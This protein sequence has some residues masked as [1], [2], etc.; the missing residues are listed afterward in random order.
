MKVKVE[1]LSRDSWVISPDKELL[2]VIG[3][4][5]GRG[6]ITMKHILRMEE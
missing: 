4:I 2:Y 5:F 6:D 1:K 3:R